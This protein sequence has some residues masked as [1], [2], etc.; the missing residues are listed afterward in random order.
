MPNVS[1]LR[2]FLKKNMPEYMVPSAF[3]FLDA[4]PITPNGKLDRKALPEPQSRQVLD[5]DFIAPR[6]PLE[7]Q[8]AEIWSNVLRID[9]VGIHDNFFE[10][11]GHSLFAVSST[12][13]INYSISTYPW[14][15]VPIANS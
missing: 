13:L 9:R 12:E 11:G 5:A 8:L 4:L 1:E 6:S 7:K 15:N 14:G 10:I 3:V 2:E